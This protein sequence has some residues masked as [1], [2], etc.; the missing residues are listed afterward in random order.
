MQ[1]VITRHEPTPRERDFIAAVAALADARGFAPST[2]EVGKHLG[3]SPTRAR[4]LGMAA[5]HNGW[6]SREPG[7]ARSWVTT[8]AGRQ[9]TSGKAKR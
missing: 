5:A 7:V 4:D 2:A 3:I 1:P 8:D 6:V 9:V